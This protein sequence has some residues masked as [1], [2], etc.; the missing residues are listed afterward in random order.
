MVSSIN[1]PA[2]SVVMPVHNGILYLESAVRSVLEQTFQNFEL[3]AINDGSTD[4]SAAM[5][6]QLARED[7]RVR[8]I[9]IPK[10]GMRTA[11]NHGL[12]I[13]KA[14]IVAR[15]DQ[16]DICLPDR[17]EKQYRYL[18]SHP[19]VLGVG[20][21][22]WAMDEAGMVM[23]TIHCPAQWA[24]IERLLWSGTNCFIHPAMM[25][26]KAVVLEVGAY[27]DEYPTDEYGLWL[28]MSERGELRNLQDV[29]LKYRMTASQRS[30]EKHRQQREAAKRVLAAACERR[31]LPGVSE[32]APDYSP[33][34]VAGIHHHWA[35]SAVAHGQWVAGRKHA[36]AAMTQQPANLHAWWTLFKALVHIKRGPSVWLSR[37]SSTLNNV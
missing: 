1:I 30:I 15:M 8:V 23:F 16:D 31:G 10:S 24:T 29:V 21:A 32:L 37:T 3:L 33:T 5:L 4:E 27:Q 2:V 11:V 36:W 26:R 28:R 35:M 7:Q 17:F 6:E 25:Y 19:E 9:H 14:D 13:A 20:G 34:T 22:A 12:S 18:E